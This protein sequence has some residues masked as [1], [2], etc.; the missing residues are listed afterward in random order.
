M[1]GL[2]NRVEHW[3][4]YPNDLLSTE[5]LIKLP[6]S[7]LVTRRCITIVLLLNNWFSTGTIKENCNQ[8]HPE[9][10]SILA[11]YMQKVRAAEGLP[12]IPTDGTT[13][14]LHCGKFKN[15][16]KLIEALKLY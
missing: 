11:D 3:S 1:D 14:Y 12:F 13:F 6:Q 5:P 15:N 9:R 10:N 4:T 16:F 2:W 8:D 7:Q